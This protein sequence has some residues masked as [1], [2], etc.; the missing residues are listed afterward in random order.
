[1]GAVNEINLGRFETYPFIQ[2][3]RPR[4]IQNRTRLEFSLVSVCSYASRHVGSFERLRMI[5]TQS[6]RVYFCWNPG[7]RGKDEV[8]RAI[9]HHPSTLTFGDM[10]FDTSGYFYFVLCSLCGTAI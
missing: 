6:R 4:L 3:T 9:T 7:E 5:R 1:M 2:L 8:P 10:A